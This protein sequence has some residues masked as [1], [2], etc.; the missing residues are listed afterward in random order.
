MKLSRSARKG[1]LDAASQV[2]QPSTVIY[3]IPARLGNL[4]I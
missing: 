4:S 1:K 3:P 2:I